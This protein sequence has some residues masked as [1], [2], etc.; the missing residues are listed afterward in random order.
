M[1]CSKHESMNAMAT[2]DKPSQW[3]AKRLIYKST[4]PDEYKYEIV[5]WIRFLSTIIIGW[6]IIL[7]LARWTK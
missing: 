1:G 4:D 7:L 3:R 2:Y 5:K 6:A